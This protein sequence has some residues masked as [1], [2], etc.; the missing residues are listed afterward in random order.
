MT[1]TAALGQPNFSLHKCMLMT[2]Y[3]TTCFKFRTKYWLQDTHANSST[4]TCTQA[5]KLACLSHG[6]SPDHSHRHSASLLG[7]LPPAIGHDSNALALG[8]VG[9]LAGCFLLYSFAVL[10]GLDH[11]AWRLQNLGPRHVPEGMQGTTQPMPPRAFLTPQFAT[12][13]QLAVPKQ[14]ECCPGKNGCIK[15][16]I[17]CM[18]PAGIEGVQQHFSSTPPG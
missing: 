11:N 13:P 4:C 14:T 1:S 3:G 10:Q 17:F 8:I 18:G 6:R 12:A 15:V 9:G 7:L 2:Q 5:H 16:L